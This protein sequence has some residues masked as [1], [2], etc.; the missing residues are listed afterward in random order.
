MSKRKQLAAMV[1]VDQVK[2][3]PL[4]ERR[5]LYHAIRGHSDQES[6]EQI[7][8]ICGQADDGDPNQIWRQWLAT[9]S[10]A[11]EPKAINP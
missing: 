3:W 10:H 2:A 7:Q 6:F 4:E 8:E 5:K 11:S 9:K 1:A